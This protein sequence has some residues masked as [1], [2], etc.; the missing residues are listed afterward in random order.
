M[1]KNDISEL[2]LDYQNNLEAIDGIGE[3]YAKALHKIS[4][5]TY[6]DLAKY[7]SLENLRQDLIDQAGV[8]IPLWKIE[9]KKS[10]QGSWIHQARE[11]EKVFEKKH[12]PIKEMEVSDNGE[13]E[14]FVGFT[15]FFES[16]TND[17]DESVWQTR[18]YKSKNDGEG[19]EF[20]G[21]EPAVWV[22]WIYEHAQL[23]IAITTVP[24]EME[25][26]T[27]TSE[28]DVIPKTLD[29][30]SIEIIDVEVDEDPLSNILEKKLNAEVHFEILEPESSDFLEK[31]SSFL[32]EM[33][34]ID[35]DDKSCHQVAAIDSRFV[36][37]TLAY[38]KE[39]RF[40]M[41]SPG[42]YE[43]HT[44]LLLRPPNEMLVSYTGPIINIVPE[45]INLEAVTA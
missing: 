19:D 37:N 4:V 31:R 16:K 45:P 42:R 30:V 12:P 35:R 15:V 41:P 43:L 5:H 14:E 6:A 28:A 40:D 39:A 32:I 24:I 2:E 34:L 22:N 1:A 27:I 21:V 13:W 29:P 17:K 20:P 3:V 9:N 26:D 18:T 36:P 23:P 10:E 8:D 25:A 38:V 33:C 44:I 7:D 11:K